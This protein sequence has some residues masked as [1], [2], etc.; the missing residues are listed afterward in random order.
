MGR[1]LIA[2][3][4]SGIVRDA[5]LEKGHE[6]IGCDIIP[7][8]SERPDSDQYYYQGDI[9]DILYEHWD[10][11]IAHPPCTRL[12][13]SGV[14]WLHERN[15]WDE[16]EEGCNFFKL[17]LNHPTCER[18]CVENPIIHGYATERIGKTYDQKIQPWQ[19]GHPEKKSICLWLKNLPLLEPTEIVDTRVA[20]VHN[21]GQ[22][23]NRGKIR[24]RFY[25]GIGRA[26]SNQWNLNDIGE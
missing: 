18:I 16:L 26:M 21:V 19:F 25:T 8:E 15:L 24:S 23:K 1:I 5:F 9:R 4:Y 17:F 11:I 13:H 20:R 2:C 7:C 14:R 6:A 12:A 10:M 3:E 22:Q